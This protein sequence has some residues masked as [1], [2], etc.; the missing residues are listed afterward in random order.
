MLA[1]EESVVCRIDVDC[2]TCGM[3]F[4]WS[5]PNLSGTIWD[6]IQ[7]AYEDQYSDSERFKE[8]FDRKLTWQSIPDCGDWERDKELRTCG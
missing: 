3:Q 6:K 5:H 7:L 4:N 8:Y 2:D 1:G